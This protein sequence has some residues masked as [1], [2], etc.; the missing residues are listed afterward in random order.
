MFLNWRVRYTWGPLTI[1]ADFGDCCT[2]IIFRRL[3]VEIGDL[4]FLCCGLF[5]DASLAFTK[6][7]GF[8]SLSLTVT[9]LPLGCCGLTASVEAVFAPDKKTLSFTPSW[10]GGEGCLTVYG[11]AVWSGSTF[12]G[13]AVYGW[14]ISCYFDRV[15]L[16]LVTALDPD[17]V[18]D[19]TD[20]TFYKDEFEY[21]GITYTGEGC[22][23]GTVTF[24][25]ELWF[26]TNGT[27]FGLQRVRF[28]LEVPVAP[29]VEMF[30]KGQWN[31]AKASPLEWFDLGWDFSF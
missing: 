18:E 29:T 24:S 27:L 17:E 5:L 25:A 10:L 3:A 16:R 19:M 23:G 28:K 12:E 22:C 21:L 15:K 1:T 14:G 26:G 31:F 11:N 2:G 13:I 4:P 30:A 6:C 8:E 9:G 7:R 20:V